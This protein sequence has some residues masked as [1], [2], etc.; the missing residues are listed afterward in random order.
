MSAVARIVHLV[1]VSVW[2]GSVVFVSFVAAPIIF[3]TLPRQQA[4]DVVGAIF[5][6]YYIVGLIC[7]A[8]ALLSLLVAVGF[9]EG[10]TLR[11][12]AVGLFLVLMLAA[13]AYA[14]FVVQPKARQV[15]AEMRRAATSPEAVPPVKLKAEF[16]RLHALSVQLNGVVLAGGLCVLILSAV[17]LEI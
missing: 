5:P 8:V 17:K 11:T 10:W 13:N 12:A 7:G 16:N 14:A 1:A 9:A 6:V 4:G 15:K 3:R 2:L